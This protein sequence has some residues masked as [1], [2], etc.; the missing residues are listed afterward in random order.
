MTSYFEVTPDM[1]KYLPNDSRFRLNNQLSVAFLHGTVNFLIPGVSS[2]HLCGIFHI[3]ARVAGTGY[4]AIDS[5]GMPDTN[6]NLL[7]R[8][9]LAWLHD[10][11]P[12]YSDFVPLTSENVDVRLGPLLSTS[13]VVSAPL[14]ARQIPTTDQYQRVRLRMRKR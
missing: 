6:D 13:A 12:L 5:R 1:I 4:L 14:A 7:M 11:S 2:P 8:D 9:L 10:N 3:A